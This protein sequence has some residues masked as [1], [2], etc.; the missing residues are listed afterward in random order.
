MPPRAQLVSVAAFADKA[1]RHKSAATPAMVVRV[2]IGFS[3][4]CFVCLIFRS[5]ELV[6]LSEFEVSERKLA[7]LEASLSKP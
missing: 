1:V 6:F 2:F 4:W 3:V 5:R 7:P